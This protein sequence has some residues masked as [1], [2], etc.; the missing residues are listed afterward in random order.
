MQLY[1]GDH[2][3]HRGGRRYLKR[4]HNYAPQLFSACWLLLRG[5]MLPM[6][7]DRATFILVTRPLGGRGWIRRIFRSA[8]PRKLHRA[9]AAAPA[10]TN[11]PPACLL[12][13]AAYGSNP[14]I[15]RQETLAL[16]RSLVLVGEGGFEPPK[17]Q[18]TDLQS[19]P[20]GHSGTLPYSVLLPGVPEPRYAG[21]GEGGVAE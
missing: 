19:A 6:K 4:I 7:K 16:L 2:L 18:P 20:F 15:A 9:A 3:S 10:P 13:G 8:T 12:Y 21:L 1:A 5:R 14:P 11:M 17:V